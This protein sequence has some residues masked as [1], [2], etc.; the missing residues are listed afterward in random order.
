MSNENE[1]EES[2]LFVRDKCGNEKSWT[3]VSVGSEDFSQ[4][5]DD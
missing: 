1:L 5:T 4:L 2:E 3:R